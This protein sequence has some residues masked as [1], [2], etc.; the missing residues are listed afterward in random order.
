MFSIRY[1]ISTIF[2]IVCL[3]E[4]QRSIKFAEEKAA[5][6]IGFPVNR[7]R[8]TEINERIAHQKYLKSNPDLETKARKLQCMYEYHSALSSILIF[9]KIFIPF[10]VNVD[11]DE[12]RKDWI[13]R[14]GQFQIKSI[15]SHYGI[16]EHL[17]GYAYFVPRVPLDIQVIQP[18]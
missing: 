10:S 4:R 16:Y 15:A 1:K 9:K 12:V 8:E 11:A 6:D 18:K 3:E 2:K 7:P 17:F 14:E 5:V 13:E